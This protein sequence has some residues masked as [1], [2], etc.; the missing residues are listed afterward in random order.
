MAVGLIASGRLITGHVQSIPRTISPAKLTKGHC[1]KIYTCPRVRA[2]ARLKTELSE[3]GDCVRAE[4]SRMAPVP[5]INQRTKSMKKTL[6]F[7]PLL[8]TRG[9][10]RLGPFW[11]QKE[12]HKKFPKLPSQDELE[13]LFCHQL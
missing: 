12:P 9:R 2:P 5:I 3:A 11:Y 8:P 4:R 1:A 7:V 10:Y 13:F 6:R